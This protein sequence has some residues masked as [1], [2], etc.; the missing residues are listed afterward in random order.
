[1]L[2]NKDSRWSVW[3]FAFKHVQLLCLPANATN[4]LQPLHQGIIFYLQCSYQSVLLVE[5]SRKEIPV[6][7]KVEQ[8]IHNGYCCSVGG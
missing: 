2:K 3:G 4:E 1:V 7:N 6:T 5:G 8:R